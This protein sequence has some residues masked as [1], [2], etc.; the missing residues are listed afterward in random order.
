ML[1]IFSQVISQASRGPLQVTIR[2]ASLNLLIDCSRNDCRLFQSSDL[3]NSIKDLV[4]PSKAVSVDACLGNSEIRSGLWEI[5]V[6]YRI[7]GNQVSD[8][9]HLFS[10]RVA[11]SIIIMINGL[12]VESK[13]NQ[14]HIKSSCKRMFNLSF[15]LI[16]VFQHRQ[17]S[18]KTKLECGNMD[19]STFPWPVQPIQPPVPLKTLWQYPCMFI[20]LS[21]REHPLDSDRGAAGRN[22]RWNK[23]M[24]SWYRQRCSWQGLP[25]QIRWSAGASATGG[26]G[27]AALGNRSDSAR[28]VLESSVLIKIILDNKL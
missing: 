8:V 10:L 27:R 14:K 9:V 13:V 19:W 20:A 16:N 22:M 3:E 4:M 24:N 7:F 6:L 11:L 2:R 25:L 28:L 1:A 5:L 15:L 17:K 18:K 12:Y 26:G 23:E 21:L